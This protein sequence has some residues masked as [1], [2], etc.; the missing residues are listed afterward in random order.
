MRLDIV[1][2]DR[3]RTYQYS[4][5]LYSYGSIL[6][7]YSVSTARSGLADAFRIRFHKLE[8]WVGLE[9]TMFA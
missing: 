3:N 4:F 8:D 7:S 9:P 2:N 5:S 6:Y 1:G